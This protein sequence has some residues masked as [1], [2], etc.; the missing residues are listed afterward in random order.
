MGSLFSGV[1]GLDLGLEQAGAYGV[2]AGVDR[3]RVLGN[4]V[5]VACGEAVGRF[6]LSEIAPRAGHPRVSAPSSR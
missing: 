4:A 1:L 6:F 5:H 3:N 2:P